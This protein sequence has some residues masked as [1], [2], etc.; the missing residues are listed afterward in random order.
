MKILSNPLL[1]RSATLATVVFLF[2]GCTTAYVKSFQPDPS[3][4]KTYAVLLFLPEGEEIAEAQRTELLSFAR[5][6]LLASGLVNPQDQ[7][8]D[9]AERA[10]LLFRARVEGGQITEIAGVPTFNS[11]SMIVLTQPRRIENRIW[12]DASYPFGYS[13]YRS[14]YFNSGFLYPGPGWGSTNRVQDR[15]YRGRGRP[16]GDTY[17]DHNHDDHRNQR[18]DNSDNP[19]PVR[20]PRDDNDQGR[21]P[22]TDRTNDGTHT[23]RPP[24]A[25][26]TSDRPTRP[27]SNRDRSTPRRSD[28]PGT[29]SD[30]HKTDPR[31]DPPRRSEPP[32]GPRNESP[33]PRSTPHDYTPP[34]RT[35]SPP[36]QT[37]KSSPPVRDTIS[38]PSR[39]QVN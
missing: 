33:T 13:S 18:P 2:A 19:R 17:V 36:P 37:E 9:D 29:Q 3:T 1:L 12:W 7:L 4:P 14:N 39:R 35:Y 16:P 20:P 11:K 32:R 5:D 6:T 31:D 25:D 38:P 22:R 23:V 27:D 21:P 15:P 10:E 30:R 28:Y 24:S 26:N 34:E 8:I